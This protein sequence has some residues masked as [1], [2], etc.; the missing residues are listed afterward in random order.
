MHQFYTCPYTASV[1]GK[2]LYMERFGPCS[3]LGTLF[4]PSLSWECWSGFL[5]GSHHCAWHCIAG[6]SSEGQRKRRAEQEIRTPMT[7]SLPPSSGDHPR[8]NLCE[9]PGHGGQ[10]IMH[11]HVCVRVCVCM[12]VLC[13]I[14]CGDARFHIALS[15][16]TWCAAAAVGVCGSGLVVITL[17]SRSGGVSADVEWSSLGHFTLESAVLIPLRVHPA[18]KDWR[19]TKK[20]ETWTAMFGSKLA[21]RYVQVHSSCWCTVQRSSQVHDDK[22]SCGGKTAASMQHV[23]YR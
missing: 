14:I 18:S 16:W 17:P 4:S 23:C 5:F 3:I 20:I 1:P 11:Q 22:S 8:S 10:S 6:C 13:V 12:Y 19:G 7:K 21:Q 9:E 2:W 15:P